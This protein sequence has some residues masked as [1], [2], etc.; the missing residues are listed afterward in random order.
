VF[1][2]SPVTKLERKLK[3]ALKGLEDKEKRVYAMRS[4]LER[5]YS[6]L[7][8]LLKLLELVRPVDRELYDQFHPLVRMAHSEA[9]ELANELDELEST[10]RR[11][12]ESLQRLLAF[13]Q[14]LK[15]RSRKRRKWF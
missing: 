13:V 12:K 5:A 1:R 11:D 4:K 7:P 9:M 15:E 2:R 8:P 10:I 14:I 6:E 3:Q